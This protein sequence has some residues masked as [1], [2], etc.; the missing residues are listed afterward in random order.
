MHGSKGRQCPHAAE[1]RIWKDR[2]RAI[3]PHDLAPPIGDEIESLIPRRALER[4]AAF[5][6]TTAQRRQQAVG[7]VDTLEVSV[8]LDAQMA[9]GHWMR[10]IRRHI[11]R[12]TIPYRH[13]HR[14]R[15]GAVMG[16]RHAGN[17]I[18]G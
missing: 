8:D 17:T 3:D 13:K 2:R 15:V 9:A 5:R 1:I 4:P 6:A 18:Y 14:A 12:S 16:T 11:D 7:M 10:R